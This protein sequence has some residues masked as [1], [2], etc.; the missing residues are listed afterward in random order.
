ML[1]LFLYLKI[2][3]SFKLFSCLKKNNTESLTRLENI[4]EKTLALRKQGFVTPGKVSQV[5]DGLNS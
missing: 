3:F 5:K 1:K 2:E 4:H